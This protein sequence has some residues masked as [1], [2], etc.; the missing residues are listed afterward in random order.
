MKTHD[1]VK[2]LTKEFVTYVDQ[3][4]EERK[5][6]VPKEK[7]RKNYSNELFGLLPFSLKMMFKK[8]Q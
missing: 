3:P 7:Y 4:K 2:F 6:V 1:F 5:R 8:K